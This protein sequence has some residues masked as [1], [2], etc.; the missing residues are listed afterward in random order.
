MY[1][2]CLPF[3][4]FFVHLYLFFSHFLC[5]W[6]GIGLLGLMKFLCLSL[7]SP[8]HSCCDTMFQTPPGLNSMALILLIVDVT[9]STTALF[10]NIVWHLFGP[11]K[12]HNLA[13]LGLIAALVELR[14]SPWLR[15]SLSS[16]PGD[17]PRD[18][19]PCSSVGGSTAAGKSYK[20]SPAHQHCSMQTINLPLFS[21]IVFW[22]AYSVASS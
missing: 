15:D 16:Q 19:G 21:P 1:F 14:Q 5:C 20:D 7:K 10:G 12:R 2:F 17:F 22:V 18:P 13:R 9:M 6:R 3:L 11:N 4:F 8:K